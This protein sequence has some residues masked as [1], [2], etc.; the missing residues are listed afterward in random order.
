[1]AAA[2]DNDDDAVIVGGSYSLNFARIIAGQ[3]LNSKRKCIKAQGDTPLY[4]SVLTGHW[5]LIDGYRLYID[6]NP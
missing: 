3:L 6:T 1:M 4:N 5:T 2:A